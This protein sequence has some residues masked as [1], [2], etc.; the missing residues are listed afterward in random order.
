MQKKKLATGKKCGR[1]KKAINI[2]SRCCDGNCSD[3]SRDSK[4]MADVK[5]P[6][7]FPIVDLD[8]HEAGLNAIEGLDPSNEVVSTIARWHVMA[9]AAIQ[10]GIVLKLDGPAIEAKRGLVRGPCL[11]EPELFLL[12]KPNENSVELVYRPKL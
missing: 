4:S 6:E 11:I 2:K 9:I 3:Y 10:Y 12:S 7:K 8:F 5:M 1:V